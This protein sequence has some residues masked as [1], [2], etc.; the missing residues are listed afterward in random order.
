M[1]LVL[2]LL[3]ASCYVLMVKI[4]FPE[5]LADY[6]SIDYF[7]YSYILET[8]AFVHIRTRSSIKFFAKFITILNVIFLFYMNNYMYAAQCQYFYMLVVLTISIGM[9][10][11]EYFEIPAIQD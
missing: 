5:L 2:L 6:I 11:L 7:C 9:V 4:V 8:L 10:F 1:F 3:T